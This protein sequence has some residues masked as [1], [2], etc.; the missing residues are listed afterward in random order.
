MCVLLGDKLCDRLQKCAASACHYKVGYF[1]ILAELLTTGRAPPQNN[2][3]GLHREL[4]TAPARG[5]GCAS[6]CRTTLRQAPPDA[7]ADD[8][9]A[10]D[11]GEGDVHASVDAS[12][13]VE[14]DDASTLS[15][16]TLTLA[17][18]IYKELLF[19]VSAAAT[20]APVV[21]DARTAGT[22]PMVPNTIGAGL[23]RAPSACVTNTSQSTL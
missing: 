9:G 2:S 10:D 11:A 19:M 23:L 4:R 5:T 14:A 12:V 22:A 18:Y 20:A 7:E 13:D 8:A 1:G 3:P 15:C 17:M 16:V 21:H 6:L